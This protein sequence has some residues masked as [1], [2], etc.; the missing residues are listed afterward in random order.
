VQEKENRE[1]WGLFSNLVRRK[2]NLKFQTSCKCPLIQRKVDLIL[3]CG[4]GGRES[5]P[6][7]RKKKT[8]EQGERKA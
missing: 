5:K 6:F 8:I 1:I 4:G 7:K 2:Q 3:L